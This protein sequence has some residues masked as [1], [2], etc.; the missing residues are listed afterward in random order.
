MG[1]VVGGGAVPTVIQLLYADCGDIFYM[2]LQMM[3]S[4]RVFSFFA[5]C[6]DFGNPGSMHC[7][8]LI[9]RRGAAGDVCLIT[10]P[11]GGSL[12]QMRSPLP[13][14]GCLH[15]Y[16]VSCSYLNWVDK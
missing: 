5:D 9:R 10:M 2:H 15:H 6:L 1:F 11:A 13:L 16:L 3:I 12:S 8:S 7:P 14:Q 4:H